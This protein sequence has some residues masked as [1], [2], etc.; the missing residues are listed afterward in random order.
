MKRRRRPRLRTPV[1]FQAQPV[2]PQSWEWADEVSEPAIRRMAEV[3]LPLFEQANRWIHRRVERI[4]F[5]DRE[6]IHRQV[7]VDFTLPTGVTPVGR[8]EDRDV[9]VAP[10]FLLGKDHPSP[11]RIGREWHRWAPWRDKHPAR[12]PMALMSGVS[13]TDGSGRRIPLLTRSQSN[14]LANAMLQKAAT[15]ALNEP[16]S[17]ITRTEIAAIALGTRRDRADALNGLLLK[18]PARGFDSELTA[19]GNSPFAELACSMATHAPVVCLF[20][21]GPPGRSIVK[22][23]YV[24]PMD[25]ERLPSRG[26]VRRSIGWKSEYLSMRINEVGAAASHHIELEI[27][28]ELQIN[29]VSLAGKSYILANKKWRNLTVP[30]RHKATPAD[31]DYSIH[32]VGTA[33]SGSLYMSNLPHARRMGRVAVKM[34]ARRPGFLFGALVVSVIMTAVLAVLALV[35][36]DLMKAE[37]S[38]G[39]IAALLLLPT[40][41]A[42]YIARPG[43]HLITSRMLRWA[44]FALVGNAALPFLAVLFL[45]TTPNGKET[46]GVGLGLGGVM[47]GLFGLI[48][49]QDSP[50]HGLEAR[51]ALLAGISAL[52]TCLFVISN[53]WPMPHGKSRYRPMPDLDGSVPR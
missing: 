16:I 47:D 30:D 25:D 26:R 2:D 7:S 32:Q 5:L 8:F 41:A 52:F 31:E 35:T 49:T 10:L 51:W 17:K 29:S 6:T 3:S 18:E 40:V 45:L 53:I 11:L 33:R 50:A 15:E 38:D 34:R 24:E 39:S 46:D 20:T 21:D 43:E 1:A 42:A 28:D 37:K 9:L 4:R 23:T 13:F 19:L 36:G 22:L 12:L 14:Q 27:P 48:V 44:R